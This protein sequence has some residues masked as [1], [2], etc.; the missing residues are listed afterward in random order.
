MSH[1]QRAASLTPLTILNRAQG[2][3]EST[4][5]LW[6]MFQTL[7]NLFKGFQLLLSQ[8]EAMYYY[9]DEGF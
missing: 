4:D 2:F 1:S 3:Q 8:L 6:S 7:H 9:N 5:L